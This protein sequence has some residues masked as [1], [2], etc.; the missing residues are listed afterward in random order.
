MERCSFATSGHSTPQA[1]SSATYTP[2]TSGNKSNG[3]HWQFT[4]KCTGCTTYQGSS[5]PV[6]I[7]PS[8]SKRFGFACAN[9]K[10]SNP[11][12][13]TAT[14]PVHDVYN[15]INHDFSQGQNA[16]FAALLQKNGVASANTTLV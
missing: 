7:D 12:S 16:N 5:G 13:T 3:T 4:V 15:Y 11:S 10:V 1:Y 8:S 6:R 2:L 9:G 14:I